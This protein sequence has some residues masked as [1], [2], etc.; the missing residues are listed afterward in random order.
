MTAVQKFHMLRQFSTV[1]L[2]SCSFDIEALVPIAE[3]K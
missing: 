1:A 3:Q 2:E